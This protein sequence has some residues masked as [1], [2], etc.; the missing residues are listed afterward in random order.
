MQ[1]ISLGLAITVKSSDGLGKTGEKLRWAGE[2]WGKARGVACPFL[3]DLHSIKSNLFL[4]LSDPHSC[5]VDF[6]SQVRYFA[7]GSDKFR[8]KF[9]FLLSGSVKMRSK[10]FL[11]LLPLAN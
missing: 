2:D 7:V 4:N 5:L 8:N 9:D 3:T 11:Q 6:H 1:S 10:F